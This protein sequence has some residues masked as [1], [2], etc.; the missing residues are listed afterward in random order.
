LPRINS[1]PSEIF[2]LINIPWSV[3]NVTSS[4]IPLFC[5]M[6]VEWRSIID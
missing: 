3:I 5:R 1:I 4:S 6:T 2:S